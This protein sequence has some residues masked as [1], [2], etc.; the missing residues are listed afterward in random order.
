MKNDCVDKTVVVAGVVDE[1]PVGY[2]SVVPGS[3]FVIGPII[4]V[5]CTVPFIVE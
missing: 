2:I 3:V 5:P 1:S 4:V